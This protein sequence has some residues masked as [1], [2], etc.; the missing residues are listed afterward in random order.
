VAVGGTLVVVM[1]GHRYP[2]VEIGAP[3]GT[4]YSFSCFSCHSW[5]EKRAVS[6]GK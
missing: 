1:E 6:G 3:P 5:I 2:L 4:D